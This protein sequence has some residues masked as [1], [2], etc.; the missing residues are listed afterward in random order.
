MQLGQGQTVQIPLECSLVTLV[1][2]AGLKNFMDQTQI[3]QIRNICLSK[4]KQV[5]GSFSYWHLFP[6][7]CLSHRVSGFEMLQCKS[8]QSEVRRVW[9]RQILN[10]VHIFLHS[11]Q[12]WTLLPSHCWN[13]CR[14]EDVVAKRSGT[15]SV[16]GQQTAII[17]RQDICSAA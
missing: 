12:V 6:N 1:I 2:I 16:T 7:C 11:G 15:Q 14:G 5:Q 9:T 8:P 13:P 3:R 17:H 10:H 4:T